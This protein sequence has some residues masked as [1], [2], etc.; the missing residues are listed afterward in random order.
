[1]LQ[2]LDCCS[3]RLHSPRIR[4]PRAR[5]PTLRLLRPPPQQPPLQQPP[6]QQPPP[7]QLPQSRAG[8]TRPP[9]AG[10]GAN[11]LDPTRRQSVVG[12][13]PNAAVSV[14]KAPGDGIT[15]AGPAI[16][17]TGSGVGNRLT[18]EKAAPNRA[19][20]LYSWRRWQLA[21]AHI[22]SDC[23][24]SDLKAELEQFAMNVWGGSRLGPRQYV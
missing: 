13:G 4:K 8:R 23:R 6:P 22:S 2:R 3:A 15:G 7:Q 20:F 14:A 12:I 16:I 21:A 5:I 9:Q 10:S 17:T 11:S 1:M 24:L 19:A 18:V